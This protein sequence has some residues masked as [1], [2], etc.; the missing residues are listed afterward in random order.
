[1]S[2]LNVKGTSTRH[3]DPD[4][5]TCL[6]PCRPGSL[7]SLLCVLWDFLLPLTSV[8]NSNSS[9]RPRDSRHASFAVSAL[10]VKLRI[11]AHFSSFQFGKRSWSVLKPRAVSTLHSSWKMSRRRRSR[12]R[13]P[14]LLGNRTSCCEYRE[15]KYISLK[16]VKHNLGQKPK[17]YSGN[18][19]AFSVSS[20]ASTPG[21]C[22][23]SGTRGCCGTRQSATSGLPCRTSS[24]RK[25]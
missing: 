8:N 12:S 15:W 1:M 25:W 10:R 2:L 3:S 21:S 6:I 7:S 22:W 9:R 23:R 11:L 18:N 19:F 14:N 17:S 16:S 13:V 5:L 4:I 24:V 20:T